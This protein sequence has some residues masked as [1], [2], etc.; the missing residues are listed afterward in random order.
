[1]LKPA[2]TLLRMGLLPRQQSSAGETFKAYVAIEALVWLPGLYLLCYRY[3]PTVRF[4]E[5]KAGGDLV[6]TVGEWLQRNVPSQHAKVVKLSAGVYGSPNGR[7]FA[8]WMLLNKVLAPVSLPTKFMVA[9]SI[10][11]R[12]AA[13][14]I[15]DAVEGDE[16]VVPGLSAVADR[17]RSPVLDRLLRQ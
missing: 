15:A 5:T 1:M 3:R 17:G 8:E 16:F 9:N 10:A 7:T 13:Q 6:R 12:R 14:R 2:T 4:I 11:N